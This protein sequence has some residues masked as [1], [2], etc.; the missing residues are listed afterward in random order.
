[1]TVHPTG[2]FCYVTNQVSNTISAYLIGSDGALTPIRGSPF[3]A[4]TEPV[5]IAVDPTGRFAYVANK[6]THDISGY[7]I[8]ENGVLTPVADS[9]FPAGS[10]PDCVAI[11]R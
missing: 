11:S 10:G 3:R 7:Q 2:K 5:S 8:D 1:V 6:F 4:G 9:P